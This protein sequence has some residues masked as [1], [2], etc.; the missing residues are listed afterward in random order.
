MLFADAAG[1]LRSLQKLNDLSQIADASDILK[2]PVAV[3]SV[4]EHCLQANRSR[5]V[6]VLLKTIAHVQNSVWRGSRALESPMKNSGIRLFASL[7]STDHCKLKLVGDGTSPE[8]ILKVRTKIRNDGLT[9]PPLPK[10]LERW[11]GVGEKLDK[12]TPFKALDIMIGE[13]GCIALRQ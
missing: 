2:L 3:V 9:H 8:E 13:R 7:R 6:V 4:N 12:L 5:R 1:I 10:N 11:K